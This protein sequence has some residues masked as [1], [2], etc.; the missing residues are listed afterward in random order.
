MHSK[1]QSHSYWQCCLNI[2]NSTFT[3]QQVVL[4]SGQAAPAQ[5]KSGQAV[6]AQLKSGQAVPAQFKSG[7]AV[8]EVRTGYSCIKSGQAVPA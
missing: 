5:L 7:Q 6:P 3:G 8:P 2:Y 4:K 1:F